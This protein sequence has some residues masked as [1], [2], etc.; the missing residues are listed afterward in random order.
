MVNWFPIALLTAFSS[1]TADAVIKARFSDLEPTGMVVVKAAA[2]VPFLILPLFLMPWPG[3]CLDFWR[4]LAFLLPLEIFGLFLYM[5]VLKTSPISLSVPFL[6]F[7]PVFMVLT[8][9]F[10][11]GERI[12]I[13]GS[14]G[15]LCAAAGAYLLH[16]KAYKQGVLEPFHAIIKDKGSRLMLLVSA[17]YAISGVLG[18]R[19]VQESGPF[20]FACFYFVTLGLITF[21]VFYL[22]PR[23]FGRDFGVTGP[24][25]SSRAIQWPAFWAVGLAQSVMVI[26]HMWAIHLVAAAYMIAVKRTSILFS[27]LYGRLLFSEDETMKRLAGAGLMAFGAA[28][29]MINW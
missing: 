15:I 17:V 27:V 11:L 22:I 20:F 6:A 24:R 12:D 18:K 5:E 1:A 4:I 26:S 3:L 13:R 29:I 2:P 28:L 7:T 9:W 21:L 16:L 19:A 25:S 23:L 10:I 8:G 14:A